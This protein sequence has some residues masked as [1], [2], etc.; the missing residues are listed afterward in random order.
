M[1]KHTLLTA[2]ERKELNR[3]KENIDELSTAFL[4]NGVRWP[5]QARCSSSCMSR[6][7]SRSEVEAGVERNDGYP[8]RFDQS[9]LMRANLS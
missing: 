5:I 9:Y 6:I 2:A 7:E 8:Q 4:G 1:C 3:C